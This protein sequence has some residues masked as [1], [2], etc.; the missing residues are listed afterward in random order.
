[1]TIHPSSTRWAGFESYSPGGRSLCHRNALFEALSDEQPDCLLLWMPGMNGSEVL[2]T[3]AERRM[4]IPTIIITGHDELGQTSRPSLQSENIS[5]ARFHA[6][7][8]RPSRF[9]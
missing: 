3:L 8:P 1:M 4:T 2:K 6:I 7:L 5:C 9:K